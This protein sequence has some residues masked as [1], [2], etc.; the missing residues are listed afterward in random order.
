MKVKIITDSTSQVPIEF[1]KKHDITFIEPIIELDG[2][3]I[4]EIS[5][6]DREDFYSKMKKLNPIP[7]TSVA[8]P[9]DVLDIFEQIVKD[10]YDEAIY[11]YLTPALSNQI[12]PAKVAHKKIKDKLKV[13]FYAT[14]YAG[15]SQAPFVLYAIKLLEEG[16][17][18]EDIMKALD[19]MK[20]KIYTIGISTSF[21]ILFKSG[22]IKKSVKMTMISSTQPDA[23]A[24]MKKCP[25]LISHE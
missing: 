14:G 6:V 15:P 18:C 16:K 4:K 12:S 3:Y 22:K 11:I 5:D 17:S 23:E 2:E 24:L 9:Q 13:H 8:S 10:G 21:D 7:K 20:S 25:F 1:A 19:K